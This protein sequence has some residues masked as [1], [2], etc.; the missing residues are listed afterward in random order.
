MEAAERD[1]RACLA[2]LEDMI[3]KAGKFATEYDALIRKAEYKGPEVQDL[4]YAISFPEVRELDLLCR[5]ALDRHKSEYPELAQLAERWYVHDSVG[6]DSPEDLHTDLVRKR[7]VLR[8]ALNVIS[9]KPA[10]DS[11]EDSQEPNKRKTGKDHWP[12]V[13]GRVSFVPRWLGTVADIGG[14]I[15]IMLLAAHWVAGV[16]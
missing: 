4:A 12:T 16:L 15:G 6:M 10:S 8:H 2:S 3:E 9:Q 7:T 5:G 14:G 1:T 11:V 13:L